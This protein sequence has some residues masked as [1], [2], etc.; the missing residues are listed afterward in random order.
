MLGLVFSR[1]QYS[2]VRSGLAGSPTA[3]RSVRYSRINYVRAPAAANVKTQTFEVELFDERGELGL[4]LAGTRLRVRGAALRGARAPPDRRHAAAAAAAAR[5]TLG[6]PGALGSTRLAR[7]S[8]D[9]RRPCA[10]ARPGA[11]SLASHLLPLHADSSSGS[12]YFGWGQNLVPAHGA[13]R[14]KHAALRALLVHATAV[15][16]SSTVLAA[17]V[18]AGWSPSVRR[19]SVLATVLAPAGPANERA[20]VDDREKT[21]FL[22]RRGYRTGDKVRHLRLCSS[23]FPT[24]AVCA[25]HPER[26]RYLCQVL[27]YDGVCNLCN[28]WVNFVIDRD[29][30]SRYKYAALQGEAGRALMTRVGRNPDDLSTLV[31]VEWSGRDCPQSVQAH[32]EPKEDI[33]I[34]SEAVLRVVE[35]VGGRVLGTAAYVVR[36]LIPRSFRDFVY[37]NCVAPNRYRIFG[38]SDNCRRVTAALRP[39]FLDLDQGPQSSSGDM[40]IDLRGR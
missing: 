19:A 22:T 3:L 38:K 40:E 10:S 39:R 1:S 29:P 37:S 7:P 6:R 32:S 12:K 27:L 2:R 25:A 31:L 18:P 34:K 30:H 24:P 11:H 17:R 5:L 15:A 9:A 14:M 36:K 26:I 20:M 13:R 21:D 23:F 16:A 28:G 35:D 33:Y 4:R 8:E